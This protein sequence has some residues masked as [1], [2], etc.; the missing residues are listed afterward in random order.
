MTPPTRTTVSVVLATHNRPLTLGRAMASVLAQLHE[1]LELIVVD[2]A[3]DPATREIVEVF[4]DE[5]VRYLRLHENCGAAAARN[6]GARLARSELLAFQNDDDIWLIDKLERQVEHLG[7]NPHVGLSVCAHYRLSP[8]GVSRMVMEQHDGTG[9]DFARGPLGGFGVIATPGWLLRRSVFEQAG[10]F[11]ER[12]RSWDDWELGRRLATLHPVGYL[13]E[14]LFIQDRIQGGQMWR[15]RAAYGPDMEILL[16]KHADLWRDRTKLLAKQYLIMG[17]SRAAF[18]S[19]GRAR[20]ALLRSLSLDPLS[21]RAWATLFAT[22]GGQATY[23]QIER[24][25]QMLKR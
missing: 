22:L 6:A 8:Q 20:R 16:E 18:D 12:L 9:W 3:S 13:S 4:K 10:G 5:R 2:D 14:A 11:D 7:A 23:R 15:N 25:W 1:A 24:G 21:W 19:T 17:R